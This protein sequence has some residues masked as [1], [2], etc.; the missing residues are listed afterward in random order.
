MISSNPL[1][2][3]ITTAIEY[4]RIGRLAD[5]EKLYRQILQANP[6]HAQAWQLLGVLAY[7]LDKYP[8]A[9]QL[10]QRAIA[11]NN[12]VPEFYANLGNVF[13]KQEKFDKA[14]ENYANALKLKP[15]FIEIANELGSLLQAQNR[16]DEAMI[17]YRKAMD[18]MPKDLTSV[19]LEFIDVCGNLG[20]LLQDQEQFEEAIVCYEKILRFFPQQEIALNNLGNVY[21]KQKKFE[22]AIYYYQKAVAANPHFVEPYCNLGTVF[23]E[24]D[25]LEMAIIYYQQALNLKPDYIAVYTNLALAFQKQEQFEQAVACYQQALALE[26]DNPK[27]YH[28]LGSL[29]GHQGEIEQAVLYCRQAIV[30]KPYF[31]EAWQTLG[32]ML[33]KQEKLQEA[34]DCYYKV[35]EINPDFADAHNSLGVALQRQGRL[36]EALQCFQRTLEIDPDHDQGHFNHGLML[37]RAGDF[38]QAWREHVRRPSREKEQK[39]LEKPLETITSLPENLE[40]KRFLL[41]REQ[42]FGDELMFLRFAPRLKARG[43]WLAYRC[44]S[45]L[46]SIISRQTWLD[47]LIVED[48]PLP[49]VDYTILVGDLPLAVEMTSFEQIPPSLS[50]SVLPER[51]TV[52][53]QR[54]AEIGTGPFIGVT[55]WAGNKRE[56][57]RGKE[58]LYKE[59]P[60]QYLAEMLRPIRA[61]FL[62]LQRNPYTEEINK[63]SEILGRQVYDFSSLNDDLEEMLALLLLL[64]DYVGV[65]NTN[66]HLM[67]GLGKTAKV[68]MPYPADW[69]WLMDVDE[70][71]WFKGFK[72]YRQTV[73][74]DWSNALKQLQDDLLHSVV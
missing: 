32:V 51:L 40:G 43:A 45:K 61:T 57:V 66:M 60:L 56:E 35:L 16:I 48:E 3:M 11:L 42:G 38:A 41:H 53:R 54:L 69:R 2:Q 30:L 6:R 25:N 8:E 67:A 29:L 64:D 39:I 63:F 21:Q 59:V 26:P 1:Q 5:A 58:I 74:R 62:I 52:L 17:C 24:Q 13:R 34:I 20:N 68:L 9:E 7:Q 15:D 70:S 27:I 10:I 72:I 50:F 19:K 36:Q 71:P 4:H 12:T 73:T 65:S 49:T 44:G 28:E 18:A 55:W 33:Q 23:Q 37:M 47:Q 46:P 31:A 14:I 22:E